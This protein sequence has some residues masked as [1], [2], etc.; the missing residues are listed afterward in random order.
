M[1]LS[2]GARWRA[3]VL[4]PGVEGLPPDVCSVSSSE[5]LGLAV[6]GEV[7]L[8]FVGDDD[9]LN[10]DFKVFGKAVSFGAAGLCGV[11]RSLLRC[12]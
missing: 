2:M 1:A 9:F 4:G 7:V 10:E 3:V 6:M 5:A 11:W 12:G 8:V